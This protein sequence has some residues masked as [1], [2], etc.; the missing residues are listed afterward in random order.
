[1]GKF[2]LKRVMFSS[3]KKS[4]K[5]KWDY[6]DEDF[7]ED[8]RNDVENQRVSS[9]VGSTMFGGLLGGAAGH[10]M[11]GGKGMLLGAGLGAAAGVGLHKKVFK[12]SIYEVSM[13]KVDE[14]RKNTKE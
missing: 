8:L 11:G 9:A 12:P 14:K 4:N 1:M 6:E 10:S 2:I 5:N 3:K 7:I 13:K